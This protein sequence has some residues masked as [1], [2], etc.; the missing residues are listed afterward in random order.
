MFGGEDTTATCRVV[1]ITPPTA[2]RLFEEDAVGRTMQ[3]PSGGRV[4]IIGIVEPAARARENGEPDVYY[5][6]GQ[7]GVPFSHDVPVTFRV[8]VLPPVA[9]GTLDVKVVSSDYF[10][11]MGLERVAGRLFTDGG[12]P[13]RCRVGVINERAAELYFGG[14]A[15]GGAVIDGAGRRTAI[16]GV[17]REVPVRATQRRIE[18]TLYVPMSQLFLARMHMIVGAVEATPHLQETIRRR[19]AAVEGGKTDAVS[20]MALDERLRRTALSS[21]RIA[22]LL[23]T[24]AS[25]NAAIIGILGLHRMFA[26]DVLLHRREIAV[27]SAL[28]APRWRLIQMVLT[29]AARLAGA[30]TVLG[31]V[32]AVLLARWMRMAV[33][34]ETVAFGWFWISGPLAL[35]VGALVASVLP[36]REILRV[37]PLTAMRTD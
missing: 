37:S 23:L 15:A 30:G 36:A 1:V 22:A 24:A 35:G 6:A 26:D 16:L 32:A 19:I 25:I 5:Y 20:V 10:G 14:A 12:E 9:M 2:A 3:D 27:R 4:E 34:L 18:P 17:V 11:I 13:G 21:E 33:G 29:R 7:E 8:P 31:I 28:G